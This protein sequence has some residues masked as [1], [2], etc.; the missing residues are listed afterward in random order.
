M[1]IQKVTLS[2]RGGRWRASFQVRYQEA[3]AVR[4]ARRIGPL[5]GVDA[6]VRHLATLS[7]PVEGLTDENGHIPNPNILE[8]QLW[9]LR[10]L[11][12]QIARAQT[13]SRSQTRLVRRRARFYGCITK[14]RALHLH[15]ITNMLAGSFAI[16]AVED[17]NVMGMANRKR[18]LGRRLA[19]ASL[20]EL[21]RQLTYKTSDRG[22]QL[23]VVGRHYPSTKTCSSCG[24]VK[25]KLPLSV[26]VF[27]CDDCG[28]TLDRDVNAAR[29]IAREATRLLEHTPD[30][31]DRQDGTGLRTESV[32]AAP[33]PQKTTQAQADLAAVA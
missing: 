1:T 8:G 24:A 14:T 4:P 33:R 22:Y 28:T 16:V 27:E 17:L 15:R 10:K 7:E 12:R 30:H 5:V 26:R 11:D 18:H 3:P 31:D 23:V 25:A 29:N 20:G 19:D 21:R 2:L 32:N 6:G 9:R 13:G